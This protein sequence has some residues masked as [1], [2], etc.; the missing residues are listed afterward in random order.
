MRLMNVWL[1][2]LV[3]MFASLSSASALPVP[4]LP[5]EAT[6]KPS[7]VV[8]VRPIGELLKDLS[9]IAKMVGQ[10]EVFDAFEPGMQPVLDVLDL[11]KPVGF[12]AKVGPAGVDST[13]VLL[14]PVKN[15]KD[16]LAIL[17]MFGQNPTEGEGGLFSLN[18]PGA[19]FGAIFR[20]ANGYVYATLKN[21]P[22]AEAGL[23]PTKIY[24]PAAL[25]KQDDNSLASVTFNVDAMPNDLKRKGLEGLEEF[26]RQLR[27][28][29]LP[30][31]QNVIVRTFLDALAEELATKVQSFIV[32]TQTAV[33]RFE[34]DR[35]KEDLAL[36]FRLTPRKGSGL[37]N[38][39]AAAGA[40]KGLGAGIVSPGSAASAFGNIIAP[41]SLKKTLDPLIDDL[42]EK[43]WKSA[44]ADEQPFAKELLEILGPTMKAGILD[45][46]VDLRGPNADN[47]A[48][49]LVAVQV[50]DA[51]RLEA[52]LRKV[53]GILPAEEK[54]NI[55][56]DVA[57][58]GGIALH[59]FQAKLDPEAERL[60][61]LEPQ[62]VFAFRKDAVVFAIGPVTDATAA[63]KST[64]DTPVKASGLIQ[65]ATSLRKIAPMMERKDP[66][67]V[68][69]AKKA[70]PDGV[71]DTYRFSVTGGDTLDI[72]LSSSTRIIQFGVLL[73]QAKRVR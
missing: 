17:N 3:G 24:A 14:V 50:Q 46:G 71:D 30:K 18:I 32:D 21:T 54:A 11:E 62:I 51:T 66:G 31:E 34:F 16:F 72:R 44:K 7:V 15:Q 27:A 63:V 49:V 29:E 38:D 39:L 5:P 55:K 37:A 41:K 73:E 47:Y 60:F 33:V 26:L 25:F 2:A 56:L 67:A 20:F 4:K 65:S 43:G 59:Q 12:Y 22:D 58:A 13:G 69:A 23:S 9:Y 42:I 6:D 10:G 64:L 28:N 45:F 40:G 35:K 19:P 48:A 8:R 57:K 61:G 1:P 68:E 70:Y 52:L 36:N 53:H